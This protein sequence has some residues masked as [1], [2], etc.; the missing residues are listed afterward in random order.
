MER[1]VFL[2]SLLGVGACL[3][4]DGLGVPA[5]AAVNAQQTQKTKAAKPVEHPAKLPFSPEDKEWIKNRQTKA[6][7]EIAPACNI[8][9]LK[10]NDMFLAAQALTGISAD[11]FM[12]IA[13]IESRIC[14][15]PKNQDMFTVDQ[16]HLYKTYKQYLGDRVQEI[17]KYDP[18][19]GSLLQEINERRNRGE[20]CVKDIKKLCF[21]PFISAIYMGSRLRDGRI[22]LANSVGV[23]AIKPLLCAGLEYSIHNLG[24]PKMGM[25]I[26]NPSTPAADFLSEMGMI[27]RGMPADI[28]AKSCV[29]RTAGHYRIIN[30]ALMKHIDNMPPED[31]PVIPSRFAR[32]DV[33]TRG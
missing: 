28:S 18:E 1:R 3:A 20:K 5:L 11:V 4:V 19:S 17:E 12:T 32:N 7:G 2:K 29:L 13:F 31:R 24:E 14:L 22:Y 9:K 26:R 15:D 21:N 23:Q 30:Q 16:R 10:Y 6:Q 27:R 25:C 8:V 33:Y